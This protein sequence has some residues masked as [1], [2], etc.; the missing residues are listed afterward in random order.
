MGG[1]TKTY[2][3]TPADTQ[4]LRKGVVDWLM[5]PQKPTQMGSQGAAATGG[6]AWGGPTIL[7]P[8][9]SGGPV[10]NYGGPQPDSSSPY[11]RIFQ[12]DPGT[13][14]R[15]T[16]DRVGD[17]AGFDRS[18]VRDVNAGQVNFDPSQIGRIN[19]DQIPQV[20]GGGANIDINREMIG[21]VTA[22]NIPG[23]RT[24]SV[25]QLGGANSAFFRN[26]MGQLQPAF[27]QQRQLAVAGAK[28]AAGNLSGSGY[29]NY[30]GAALN[31][32]LGDEQARLADYASQGLQTEVGRQLGVAGLNNAGNIARFQ[33]DIQAQ[34]MNQNADQSFI[35]QLLQ[36]GGLEQQGQ[37]A[38]Q[39]AGLRAL[40]ANQ[41]A[42]I[43]SGRLG[44]QAGGMNQ[45]ANLRAGISNQGADQSFMAQ[46]L[47]RRLGN[48]AAGINQNQ[49]QGNLDQ[50][51]LLQE[52]QTRAQMGDANAS[53]FLQMLLAQ[54]TA[55]VGPTT[56]QKSGGIGGFLGQ[57]AGGLIGSIG[58]PIGTAIGSKI[59][60]SIGGG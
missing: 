13:I 15:V 54:S 58:G 40:L 14:G 5:K 27:D 59:G 37:I 7:P 51:R 21:N 1:S 6:A 17:V 11:D 50:Q 56:I 23:Q 47:Q 43:E 60:K 46:E 41:G 48:Q 32:S 39:D 35:S 16:P 24:Q 20:G 3:T 53:R 34:G 30:V 55:G 22:G 28:E 2:D 57:A 12:A 36:R 10:N 33:G 38:N 49:F 18:G 29:G 52:F 19:P 9:G 4:R 31:R 25:D 44:L 8:R 45:E 42:D 26:M